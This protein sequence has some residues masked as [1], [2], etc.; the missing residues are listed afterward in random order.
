MAVAD[1]AVARLLASTAAVVVHHKSFPDVLDTVTGLLDQGLAAK[2]VLVVDNSESDEIAEALRTGLPG[3]VGLA[4]VSN[5]GYA[6]AINYALDRFEERDTP[7][8]QILVSTHETRPAPGALA[9]LLE[10]MHRHPQVGVLG[11]A[12]TNSEQSTDVVWSAGGRL[13]RLTRRAKHVGA[14][15]PV[16][17]R[18]GTGVVEAREWLD[19]SFCLYRGAAIVGRRVHMDY[20]LYFEEVDFHRTIAADG[21]EVACVVDA[22]VGQSSHGMPPF[23]YGR[24]LRLFQRRQGTSLS[25]L[26]ALPEALALLGRGVVRGERTRDDVRMFLN[27]WFSWRG[28]SAP[29]RPRR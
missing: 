28:G 14:G 27:G 19:G 13:T 20:F 23:Y 11:P 10:V 25:R 29:V 2:D 3:E 5:D 4:V 24:N 8:T 17:L 22:L 21:W 1:S 6:G 26:L 16:P 9:L 18:C 7:P 12:L 15:A